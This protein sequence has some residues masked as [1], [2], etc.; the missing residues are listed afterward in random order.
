VAPLLENRYYGSLLPD[1][2][3]KNSSLCSSHL[4]SFMASRLKNETRVEA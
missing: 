4:L 2:L 3:P 1:L